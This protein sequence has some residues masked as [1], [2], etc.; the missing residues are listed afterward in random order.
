M[1]VKYT[2]FPG[3]LLVALMLI[4]WVGVF[5]AGIAGALIA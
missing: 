5:V 2:E 1:D 3:A 4:C